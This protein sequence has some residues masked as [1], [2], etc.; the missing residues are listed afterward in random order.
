MF[1]TLPGFIVDTVEAVLGA[2]E[3]L[4]CLAATLATRLVVLRKV[5]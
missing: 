4:T 1:V 5:K 2:S 3:L